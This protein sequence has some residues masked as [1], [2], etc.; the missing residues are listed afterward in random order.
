V[1][2]AKPFRVTPIP[3]LTGKSADDTIS[4]ADLVALIGAHFYPEL[5]RPTQHHRASSMVTSDTA[6]GR[7]RSDGTRRYRLDAI[8]DWL[9][10]K[11]QGSSPIAHLLR[12]ARVQGVAAQ[13]GVGTVTVHVYDNPRSLDDACT[14]VAGLQ[15][16][17]IDLQQELDSAKAQRARDTAD[18]ECWRRRHSAKRK[19]EVPSD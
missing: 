5:D 11:K 2:K 10:R 14:M 6:N 16:Q 4:R 15:R 9:T 13:A 12:N 17:V 7:L 18:A 8:S 3:D 19:K 1:T